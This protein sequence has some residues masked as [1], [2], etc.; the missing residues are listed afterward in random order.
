MA[1]LRPPT[2]R[3]LSLVLLTT[4][5]GS[6]GA[7]AGEPVLV[8]LEGV[9]AVVR[10]PEGWERAAQTPAAGEWRV[11]FRG[12]KLAQGGAQCEARVFPVQGTEAAVSVLMQA[13][14]Q[15]S[16]Q[17]G[18]EGFGV[19]QLRSLR[20]EG[21]A[22][23]EAQL[24]VQAGQVRLEGAVRLL[25][26]AGT[27]WA[28]AWGLAPVDAPADVREVARGF[29]SSLVPSEPAF[30]EPA[31]PAG[32]PEE[33]L[34]SPPGEEPVRRRHIEAVIGAL[35][36]GAGLRLPQNARAEVLAVLRTDALEG[37][38]ATRKG[39]R[40]T[41]RALH[42]ALGQPAE[43]QLALRTSLGQGLLKNLEA[44]QGSGHAPAQRV[45]LI[46]ALGARPGVGNAEAGLTRFEVELILEGLAF[47]AALAADR[48]LEPDATQR[49]GLREALS[50]RWEA[51]DPEGRTALGRFADVAPD[52]LSAWGR[53][54]PDQRF[55]LRAGV[56]ALLLAP[57]AEP[58]APPPAPPADLKALRVCLDA[59][60]PTPE[61][62]FEALVSAAPG[63]LV[64]LT[65]L[66]PSQP[67][68]K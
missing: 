8:D 18:G 11:V 1:P 58:A 16:R 25:R 4:G 48:A 17:V 29:A 60:T 47:L 43:E 54:T 22:A 32:E 46:L 68:P 37:G 42:E 39:Y 36:A 64:R 49:A 10:A 55:A 45:A 52:L 26:A 53:A 62:L 19:P 44:R 24:V 23:A 51:L 31:P 61:A 13:A 14:D 15:I 21:R 27:A 6:R 57:P 65:A 50:T 56:A 66:L 34:V 3:A 7:H 40:D 30:Y 28:L 67:P 35:E 20:L 59:S 63:E 9:K 2:F 41:A 38:A 5:F 12:P 33:A